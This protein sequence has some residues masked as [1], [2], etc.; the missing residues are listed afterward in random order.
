MPAAPTA[1]WEHY[2][3]EADMGVRGYGATKEQAFEQAAL[4]MMHVVCDAAALTPT[5][6]VDVACQAPDDELLLVD[7]LNT[8]IYEMA[9]RH[10]LFGACDVH[11]HD[12]HLQARAHAVPI[13]VARHQPAVEIKGATYTT[14]H[15]GQEASGA[16][17]A[18]CVV[19]V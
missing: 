1:R 19:D 6:T 14:L 18:Q 8:L 7:F 4:A 5:L 2:A 11:I 10:V 17:R 16:W 9:T 12:H 15:V 13:D 3:H